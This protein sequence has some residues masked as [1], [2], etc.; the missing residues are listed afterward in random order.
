MTT[1]RRTLAIALAVAACAVASSPSPR[2]AGF[3]A[4]PVTIETRGGNVAAITVTNPG[5]HKIYLQNSVQ[6]WR[7]DP[8]GQDTLS[9]TRQPSYR[10]PAC[11]CSRARPTICAFSCRRP[12]TANSPS[13]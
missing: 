7:Q 6:E 4:R 1:H 3:D 10:R 9:D 12:A 8:S 2:A 13:A 5:D 11:G